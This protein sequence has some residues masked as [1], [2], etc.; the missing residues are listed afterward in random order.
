MTV[1]TKTIYEHGIPVERIDGTIRFE[2]TGDAYDWTQ[3]SD[4]NGDIIVIPSERVVGLS[5]TW[6]IAVTKAHGALHSKLDSMTWKGF[7]RM[8]HTDGITEEAIQAAIDVATEL[9]WEV[10]P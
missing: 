9:G 1:P 4:S 5:T 3:M 7:V 10:Q 6:P 2:S 8:A